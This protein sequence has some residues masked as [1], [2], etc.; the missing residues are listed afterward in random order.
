M[1]NWTK[2]NN[3]YIHSSGLGLV[4]DNFNRWHIIGRDVMP[5]EVSD[6]FQGSKEEAMDYIE[7]ISIYIEAA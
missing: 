2:D 1:T 3:A 4:H 7:Q 5:F 6:M